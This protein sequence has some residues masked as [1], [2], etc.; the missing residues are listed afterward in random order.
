MNIVK[1]AAQAL[2]QQTI[3]GRFME[4]DLYEIRITVNFISTSQLK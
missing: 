4:Y 1:K 3:D 2:G